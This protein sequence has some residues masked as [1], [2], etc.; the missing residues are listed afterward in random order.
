MLI[1][2][3]STHE[4]LKLSMCY[5]RTYTWVGVHCGPVKQRENTVGRLA[6]DEES[7]SEKHV[8]MDG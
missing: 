3:T 5:D 4:M 7:L 6:F 8:R 2:Y 1:G